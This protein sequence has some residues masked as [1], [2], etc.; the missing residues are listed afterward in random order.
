MSAAVFAAALQVL[1]LAYCYFHVVVVLVSGV[2]QGRSIQP[3]DPLG[4]LA[5]AARRLLLLPL[6]RKG[7][8][9]LYRR[10]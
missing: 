8:A 4:L 2:V 9:L 1:S 7:R 6:C 5:P 10:P 3:E